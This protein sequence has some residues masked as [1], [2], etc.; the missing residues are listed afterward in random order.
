[1]FAL[2]Q[3]FLLLLTAL[4][5]GG[6][7]VG[8]KLGMDYVS[9]FTFTFFR[10]LIGALFLVPVIMIAS[11][12]RVKGGSAIRKS[13][14]SDFIWGSLAVGACL[15]AAESFQ[16]YGLKYTDVHK[17]SF[18]TAMY[19]VLVPVLGLF[20]GQKNRL[21]IWIAVAISATGLGFLTLR[22]QSL[23]MEPGDA[24]V[25][26]CAL[27]FAVHVQVIDYWV[28]RV[29]GVL[30]SFGQFVVASVLGLVLAVINGPDS[31][32]AIKAAMPAILYCG[33][34]SNGI[35]YT[36]QIVGQRGV[37]PA[38]ASIVLSLE[39]AFGALAGV[40]FLGE[41][42]TAQAFTGCALM[43]TATMIAVIPGRRKRPAADGDA[44]QKK[45]G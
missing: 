21:R 7:F 25:L 23:S 30:L 11:R 24:M 5:W 42:M 8:Q 1:M 31:W 3:Y 37:N 6:G 39:S 26:M 41:R 2:R 44:E 12:I 4:G 19:V 22:G 20:L 14:K 18:I 36:L 16:Q 27:L 17:A 33:I 10:T 32:E 38:G 9:P 13:S 40:L 34:V 15:I 29:D 35:A 28:R 45:E 43:F